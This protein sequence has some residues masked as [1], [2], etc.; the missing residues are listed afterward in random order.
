MDGETGFWGLQ[1]VS[2]GE[3]GPFSKLGM[4]KGDEE[5]RLKIG[6]KF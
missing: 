5:V 4:T 3:I 6:G 2:V 1:F